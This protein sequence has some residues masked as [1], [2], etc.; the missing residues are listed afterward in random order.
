MKSIL[1]RLSPFSPVPAVYLREMNGSDEKEVTDCTSYSALKLVS[2]LITLPEK[3]GE[4]VA[5]GQLPLSDRDYLLYLTYKNTY[6]GRISSSIKCAD[7]GKP[8]DIDFSLDDF[9]VDRR[10]TIAYGVH[11]DESG[12][13]LLDDMKIRLPRGEDELAVAAFPSELI[14]NALLSRCVPNF[15]QSDTE[16]IGRVMEE[17][18]PILSSDFPVQCPE[19]GS[20]QLT[21]F[22]M[23]SYVL[24]Q[25]M[26]D[27]GKLISEIHAIALAYGWPLVDILL[28]P[29]SER[30]TFARLIMNS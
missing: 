5:A 20:E 27:R 30:K 15:S 14:G 1:V 11:V 4:A 13:F 2:N 18:G 9:V 8:Y 25:I 10:K 22:D 17:A 7:C 29:R 6:G 12:Y 24:T 23:Q 26:N 19:C 28:L 21:R 3:N 16:R